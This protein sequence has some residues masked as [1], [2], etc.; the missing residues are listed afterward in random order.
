MRT[1]LLNI[2]WA[3]VTYS[4]WYG[5]D[6][7]EY[8]QFVLDEHSRSVAPLLMHGRPSMSALREAP[9]ARFE[10]SRGRRGDLA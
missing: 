5:V 1:A 2:P 8:A 10:T 6:A 3:L 9:T 4:D 7:D